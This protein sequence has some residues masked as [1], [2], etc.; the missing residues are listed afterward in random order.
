MQTSSWYLAQ[1]SP[2]L[3]DISK[4]SQKITAIVEQAISKKAN[5]VIFPE[6]ALTGYTLMDLVEQVAL[7]RDS[8]KFQHFEKLSKDIDIIL[9]FVE[10]DADYRFYISAAYLSHGTC[11]HIHRKVYLPTYGLFEDQRFFSA[12]QRFQAFDTPLGRVGVLI[13][14]DA[15]HLDGPLLTAIDE[16]HYLVIIASSPLQGLDAQ[17]TKSQ[18]YWTLFS[19]TY[20]LLLGVYVVFVNRVGC[21]DGISFWG[22]SMVISPMGE[23]I[24]E[25]KKFEEDHL[26]VSLSEAEIRRQRIRLPLL[27]DSNSWILKNKI[28]TSYV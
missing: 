19:K 11:V 15:W 3:G 21:E 5:I 8:A 18:E 20:A 26:F 12:G 7:R 6:L 14:E 25:A 28:R 17:G 9:G 13:C 2:C 22:G 27:K 4:N 16:A 23:V 24:S 1:T 10:E